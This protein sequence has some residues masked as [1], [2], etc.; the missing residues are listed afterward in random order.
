MV[1]VRGNSDM[2]LKTNN[3]KKTI[4]KSIK[5]KLEKCINK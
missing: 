2:I 5:K 3:K 4:I 1:M